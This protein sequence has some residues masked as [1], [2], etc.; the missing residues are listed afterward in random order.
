MAVVNHQT[1][2]ANLQGGDLLI[3]RFNAPL[4]SW[5]LAALR[6]GYSAT[7][8]GRDIG[9]SLVSFARNYL[10]EP[11]DWPDVWW[12]RFNQLVAAEILQLA[13]TNQKQ[14]AEALQDRY[15]SISYCYNELGGSCHS[16]DLFAQKL[17]NLFNDDSRKQIVFSSIH[18][19]KGDESDRCFIL[20]ADCLP[21]V[22]KAKKSW[23]IEQEYNLLY[24]AITRAKKELYLVPFGKNDSV[25]YSPG[26]PLEVLDKPPEEII[27]FPVLPET[28]SRDK[29]T[30][31]P[32]FLIDTK[33]ESQQ[34]DEKPKDTVVQ[35]SLF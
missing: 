25:V 18:R 29:A 30:Q 21:Y 31:S 22:D 28:D 15:W 2:L 5:C 20:K 4:F 11:T 17:L 14:K 35:L 12:E 23:Q 3:C 7:I 27:S 33:I 6:A 24:V 10:D 16:F 19:A 26:V 9:K 13:E 8:R 1:V 34:C 32:E